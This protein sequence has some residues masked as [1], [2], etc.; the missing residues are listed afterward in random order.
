MNKLL[1]TIALL[2]T[3]SFLVG[4]S[5]QESTTQSSTTASNEEKEDNS[6]EPTINDRHIRVQ[7]GEEA[8][9]FQ[10]NDSTAANELYNQLPLTV[11]LEDFGSNEKIFYP[12][13]K[14]NTANTPTAA[15][16]I[17]CLAYYEPWGDVVIFYDTFSP[18]G[19][20]YELGEVVA[21][22]A[23]LDAFSGEVT[24]EATE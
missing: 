7:S 1:T 17:G 16:K 20:L 5:S 10:L 14:L 15:S 23:Y 12:T 4:C 6:M 11:E 18:S 24:I 19:S 22:E 21:G 13:E 2:L 9:I 3:I 8:I